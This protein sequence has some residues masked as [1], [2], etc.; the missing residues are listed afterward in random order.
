MSE[1]IRRFHEEG[2]VIAYRNSKG[3]CHRLDG[4]ALEYFDGDKRWIVNGD[5]HREDGPASIHADGQKEWYQN[6][7]LH[8][9]DGPAIE[10]PSGARAWYVRGI[11][12][13]R[14]ES[15]PIEVQVALVLLEN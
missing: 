5:R 2:R 7:R 11:R 9:T 10:F 12:F 13:D 6:D 14:D 3:Q 1:I 4:P 15:M 8:R